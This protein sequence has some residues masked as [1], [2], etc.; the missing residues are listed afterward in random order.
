MSLPYMHIELSNTKFLLH[1][2]YINTL[3]VE[4]NLNMAYK[5]SWCRRLQVNSKCIEDKKKQRENV[6]K[7]LYYYDSF[8]HKWK[9]WFKKFSVS[10][11]RSTNG[12]NKIYFGGTFIMV[13]SIS[14]QNICD[15]S[16]NYLFFG[17]PLFRSIEISLSF[18]LIKVYWPMVKKCLQTQTLYI[19]YKY[20]KVF[21]QPIR[22]DYQLLKFLL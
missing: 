13:I 12:V 8:T 11:S 15:L 22:I 1:S 19:F 20:K 18:S 6:E 10:K 7:T 5:Y 16:N 4:V 14:Q 21:A 3:F 17:F 2:S 9:C